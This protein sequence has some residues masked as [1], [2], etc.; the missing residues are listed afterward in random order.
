[1]KGL[2]GHAGGGTAYIDSTMGF[3]QDIVKKE[4]DKED[5]IRKCAYV[6]VVVKE[7]SGRHSLPVAEMI[8]ATQDAVTICTFLQRLRQKWCAGWSGVGKLFRTVV[9]DDSW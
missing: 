6:S 3:I 5:I 2:S 9:S 8:T 7:K 1:M 4:K